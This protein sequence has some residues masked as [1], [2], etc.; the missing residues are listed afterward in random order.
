MKK[1]FLPMMD[2]FNN[3]ILGKNKLQPIKIRPKQD[4]K[5]MIQRALDKKSAVHVIYSDR[6]FIG[7]IVKYD[8]QKEQL[9]LQNFKRSI[10]LIIQFNEIKKVSLIPD[11][12]RKSQK[13]LN[14]K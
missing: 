14:Q 13:N 5:Q 7:D 2:H 3:F 6:D 10:T 9:I 1:I 11:N 8:G 12:I 4:I